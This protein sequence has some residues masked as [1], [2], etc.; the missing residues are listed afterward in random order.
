MK[1]ILYLLLALPMLVL[2]SCCN[3][4]DLAQV[5]TNLTLSNVS[6]ANGMIYAVQGDVVKI[7]GVSVTP[8]NGKPATITNVRYYVDGFL[9]IGTIEDPY[10]LEFSTEGFST[11]QRHTISLQATVLQEDKSITSVVAN[12]PMVVVADASALPE[13]AP[14]LGQFTFTTGSAQE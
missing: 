4:D 13:G 1:K 3:D 11:T 6:N 12:Y 5:E 10:A 14:A 8:T 9:L 2:A 7:D